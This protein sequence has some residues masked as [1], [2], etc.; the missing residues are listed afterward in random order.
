MV[1]SIQLKNG[2]WEEQTKAFSCMD[3]GRGAHRISCL[4]VSCLCGATSLCRSSEP[5]KQK[6]HS[7]NKNYFSKAIFRRCYPS[8]WGGKRVCLKNAVACPEVQVKPWCTPGPSWIPVP[9]VE[10]CVEWNNI[11]CICSLNPG[12]T[13]TGI[14]DFM[15]VYEVL[16]GFYNVEL[17]FSQN[18]SSERKL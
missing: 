9:G 7:V 13:S 3:V 14:L 8:Q 18:V 17:E 11:S 10:S 15:I 1:L 6:P 16:L 5:E 12:R 4:L 2:Q